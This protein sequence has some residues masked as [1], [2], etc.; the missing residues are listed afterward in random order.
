M[1]TQ[2]ILAAVTWFGSGTYGVAQAF[3]RH[4]WDVHEINTAVF[5]PEHQSW[6][7]RALRRL[8]TP[9]YAAEYNRQI[10]A[11]AERL[12]LASPFQPSR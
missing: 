8:L 2:I 1:N 4:G 3:R 10:V 6:T 5:I 12:Y 11:Q 9:F 7:L